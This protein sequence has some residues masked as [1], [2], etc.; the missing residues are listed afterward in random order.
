VFAL[1]NTNLGRL[2]L[3]IL[4]PGKDLVSFHSGPRHRF[5][6]PAVTNTAWLNEKA[7]SFDSS[8]LYPIWLPTLDTLRNFLYARPAD[9]K[10]TFAFLCRQDESLKTIGPRQSG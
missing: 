3:N 7:A 2:T 9:M 10:L 8:D 5:A 4:H 1:G 6:L